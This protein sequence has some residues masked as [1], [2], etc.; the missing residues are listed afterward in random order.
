[1]P[2]PVIAPGYVV[3]LRA[4]SSTDPDAVERGVVL[5][6]GLTW[7]VA[8]FPGTDDNPGDPGDPAAIRVVSDRD[9]MS[10]AALVDCPPEWVSSTW[11]RLEQVGPGWL[12]HETVTARWRIAAQL[13]D[14]MLAF[15]ATD[16]PVM[17]VQAAKPSTP[18]D[19]PDR[20]PAAYTTWVNAAEAAGLSIEYASFALDVIARLPVPEHKVIALVRVTDRWYAIYDGH[21]HYRAIYL[22]GN[23]GVVPS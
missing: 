18:P 7:V 3:S 5:H 10:R 8:Y 13:A 11:R 23:D 16:D 17:Q 19:E 4:S 21:S 9:V 22:A 14:V 1:M 15:D 20:M 6:S 2:F 12:G